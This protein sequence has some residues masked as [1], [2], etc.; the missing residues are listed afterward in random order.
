VLEPKCKVV[1][2][3][4]ETGSGT[5]HTTAV[6]L[7]E[8]DPETG[9]TLQTR[10]YVLKSKLRGAPGQ[11]TSDLVYVKR[12]RMLDEGDRIAR[13][14]DLAL[15]AVAPGSVGGLKTRPRLDEGKKLPLTGRWI[16][17][18]TDPSAM[19]ELK[20]LTQET[21]SQVRVE[22]NERDGSLQVLSTL[23]EN[24]FL[25]TRIGDRYVVGWPAEGAKKTDLF[26]SVE[27]QLKQVQDYYNEK[28]LLGILPRDNGTRVLALVKLRRKIKDPEAALSW[29]LFTGPNAFE[30]IGGE[31]AE[32]FRLSV[33]LFHRDPASGDLALVDRGSFF[34]VR[35]G[36]TEK[37]PEMGVTSLLWPVVKQDGK[38]LVGNPSKESKP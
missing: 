33:W 15:L 26:L 24:V 13:S 22:R 32:F 29:A 14:L 23:G 10:K 6:Y 11:S 28:E 21:L 36:L 5:L 9:F 27:K 17:H 8:K 37:T 18:A 19:G 12:I 2:N 31:L 3:S 35:V 30:A 34:R 4:G 20:A 1:F 38:I 7:K 25:A 16:E